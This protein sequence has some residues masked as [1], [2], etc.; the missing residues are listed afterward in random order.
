MA[1][2]A[3]L[4]ASSAEDSG[5]WGF[6]V[7]AA[8]LLAVVVVIGAIWAFAARRGSRIPKRTPQRGDHG[9]RGH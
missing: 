9:V 1:T 2:L 5:G 8:T 6:L 3:I 4:I 7:I